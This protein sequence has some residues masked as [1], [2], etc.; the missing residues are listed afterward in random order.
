MWFPGNGVGESHHGWVQQALGP[1][2]CKVEEKFKTMN[3]PNPSSEVW[4]YL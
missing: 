1:N 3:L 2:V 4:H